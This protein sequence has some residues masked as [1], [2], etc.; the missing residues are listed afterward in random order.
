MI[1]TELKK[2]IQNEFDVPEYR[3]GFLPGMTPPEVEQ[4]DRNVD[5]L[6]RRLQEI[7]KEIERETEAIKARFA[8]IQSRMFPVSVTFLVPEKFA[9]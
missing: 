9:R 8:N 4:F 6:R 3:Q 2:S 5:A 7:P 1:L